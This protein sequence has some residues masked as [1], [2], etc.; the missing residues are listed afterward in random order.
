[1]GCSR[2][3]FNIWRLLFS[4][5]IIDR[6]WRWKEIFSLRFWKN[7]YVWHDSFG[8]YF[9]RFIRCPLFGHGKLQNVSDPGEPKIMYCFRC[10]KITHK[11]PPAPINVSIPFTVEHN[12]DSVTG[13]ISLGNNNF[14]PVNEF[15]R[16]MEQYIG[17][18]QTAE[19][20]Q[21]GTGM[22]GLIN[23]PISTIGALT[24]A[25]GE[26][27]RNEVT[28][29]QNEE[30]MRR[31][32]AFG[33]A[34]NRNHSAAREILGPML[35][36]SFDEQ[37]QREIL[38]NELIENHGQLNGLVENH[39][40]INPANPDLENRD[41]TCTKDW[42]AVTLKVD[43]DGTLTVHG[44]NFSMRDD[45]I[46]VERLKKFWKIE[47]LKTPPNPDAPPPEVTD[48]SAERINNLEI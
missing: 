26:D 38:Q 14:V 42:K 6:K 45:N 19:N 8:A 37:T 23:S 20:N 15:R 13:M 9:N 35:V 4:R 40:Q 29:I 24:R 11:D 27:Y 21:I 32:T 36:D 12:V 30:N 41:K 43:N 44:T 1:M 47:I 10:E 17:R 16:A 34:T 2:E 5:S 3:N 33:D 39:G 18:H 25:A 48:S 31:T 22:S 28:R 7:S 46:A